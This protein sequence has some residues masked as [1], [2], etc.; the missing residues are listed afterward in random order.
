MLSFSSGLPIAKINGGKLNGEILHIKTDNEDNKDN[1]NESDCECCR[2]CHPVKCLK[3]PC[4]KGCGMYKD[5]DLDVGK[6]FKLQDGKFSP[7]PDIDKR[8]A[9]LI[10]GPAGSGKSTLASKYLEYYKKLFPERPIIIFSRKDNDPVLDRL[11]PYRYTVD[12]SI[13]T[14]PPDLLKELK[15]GACVVFDD[16]I[17]QD[18]KIN[19][20]VYKL[21]DDVL[22]VGRADNINC[23]TITHQLNKGKETSIVWIEANKIIVFP[24]A[25]DSYHINY[26]LKN[27]C[28]LK[29]KTN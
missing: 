12:E 15:G 6:D 11:R 7:V 29:F 24:K 20:A 4:C 21:M 26:A 17:F 10:S 23:I 27:Y 18:Q 16:C 1:D 13:V 2:R 14:Q 3:K 8:E 28:G 5:D 25:G 19:K 22:Q 9:F